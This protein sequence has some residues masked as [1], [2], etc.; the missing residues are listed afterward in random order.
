MKSKFKIRFKGEGLVVVVVGGV[1]FGSLVFC[2]VFLV[3]FIFAFMLLW[4]QNLG[5]PS[6]FKMILF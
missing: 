3:L 5:V 2:F 4:I 1:F 6:L